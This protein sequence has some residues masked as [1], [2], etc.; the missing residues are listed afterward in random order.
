MSDYTKLTDFAVKDNLLSGNPAKEVVGTEFDNEFNAI[1][2]AIATKA[3]L[4][5]PDLVTPNIGTPSAGVLT[6]CTGL[7]A[8]VVTGVTAGKAQQVD[9]AVTATVRATTTTL[10]T[11]LKHTL[12]DTS[13]DVTAFN[14]VAG[15]TYHVTALGAGSLV[16]SAGLNVLQGAADIVTVANDTFDVYM[17]D[18]TTCEIRNYTRAIGNIGAYLSS[19]VLVASGVSITTVTAKTITSITLTPG[20]WDV[21]GFVGIKGTGTTSFTLEAGGISLVNNT[22]PTDNNFFRYLHVATVFGVNDP[23]TST[24]PTTRVSISTDTVVYLVGYASF[25]AS[26]ATAFGKIFAR[27]VA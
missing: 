6:N 10:G 5:S 8:S 25:T 3:D 17:I 21:G 18:A 9:Q 15:V 1:A 14:G 24:C 13:A 20:D 2:T 4:N 16:H 27:R 12:S 19:Q 26:T 22:L 23:F 7:P 11:T